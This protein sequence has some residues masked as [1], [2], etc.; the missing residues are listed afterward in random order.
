[1]GLLGPGWLRPDLWHLL[2]VSRHPQLQ[3]ES[4]LSVIPSTGSMVTAS[5]SFTLRRCPVPR[6]KVCS[7][8]SHGTKELS[9]FPLLPLTHRM[10][11]T[12]SPQLG[13][14]CSPLVPPGL[15]SLS[16][17]CALSL[18]LMSWLDLSKAPSPGLSFPF[19]AKMSVVVTGAAVTKVSH[20]CCETSNS[21]T[22]RNV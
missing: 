5:G 18:L 3:L 15:A 16:A 8:L 12:R 7:P 17:P 10:F 11:S 21:S 19:W 20:A 6:P 4:V 9:E 1:M 22:M 14:L 13:L 2:P